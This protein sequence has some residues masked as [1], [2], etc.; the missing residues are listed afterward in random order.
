MLDNIICMIEKQY[1]KVFT[2][3]DSV[4]IFNL[5]KSCKISRFGY[6]KNDNEDLIFIGGR[7]KVK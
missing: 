6:A 7:V 2:Q 4:V 5:S 3:S 1:L